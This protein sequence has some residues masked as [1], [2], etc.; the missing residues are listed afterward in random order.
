MLVFR[1]IPLLHP[2]R[3]LSK[4][5]L[6]HQGFTEVPCR[7]APKLLGDL[8]DVAVVHAKRHTGVTDRTASAVAVL[9][10]HERDA[11]RSEAV[12]DPPVDI[13]PFGT[14]NVDV[15][16]RKGG[17]VAGKEP[18]EDEV[19]LQWVHLADIDEVVN[20]AGGAGAP[21]RCPDPH[22]QDHPGNLGH[23]QEV[24]GKSEVGDDPQF[25]LQPC[26]HF[27]LGPP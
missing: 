18:L 15:D 14:F 25:V 20:Q 10:A 7:E 5:W 2:S 26:P 17:P 16:V 4:L 9:H 13:V 6:F 11:F 21:G 8:A 22:V 3:E 24:G 19:V 1:E 12:K 23:C 27:R